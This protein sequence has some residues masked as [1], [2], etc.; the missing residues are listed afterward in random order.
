[1]TSPNDPYQQAYGAIPPT[2]QFPAAGSGYPG[3]APAYGPAPGPRG[4][5]SSNVVVV[6]L[7]V[8]VVAVLAAVA[9]LVWFVLRGGDSPDS[10]QAPGTSVATVTASAPATA[11]GNAAPPVVVPAPAPATG[12]GL[13]AGSTPCGSV[14]GGTGGYN[15]S[16]TGTS[17]TSC[18][19]AEEVR[20]AYAQSG[21]RG[22]SRVITAVSP[23]TGNVYDMNCV[24]NVSVVT[25]AGG[26][27]AVVYLY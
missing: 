14:Y 18:P 26:N 1:M 19:F 6:L 23:T 9:A 17:V 5:G 25:C 21:P 10:A 4:G 3:A 11:S 13:P 16:A 24:A 12:A 2:E 15:T 7:T 8:L 27:D 22:G 20:L